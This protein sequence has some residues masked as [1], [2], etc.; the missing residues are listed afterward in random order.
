[1]VAHG[2][3]E[4]HVHVFAHPVPLQPSS[5]LLAHIVVLWLHE[6]L[7]VPVQRYVVAIAVA[8]AQLFVLQPDGA[9]ELMPQQVPATQT[10]LSQSLLPFVHD[11]PATSFA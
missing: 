6:R 10:L 8:V 9:I 11:W 1:V 7:F 4:A 2:A 3:P 5:L